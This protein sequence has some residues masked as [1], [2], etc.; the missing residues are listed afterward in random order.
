M[1]CVYSQAYRRFKNNL[2]ELLDSISLWQK[3]LKVIGGKFGTSVLS[4][5]N[6]LRWLLKFNIFSFI[7]TFSFIIIPQLTVMEKNHLQF[8][9]LEFLTGA[10][11]A[12]PTPGVHT[13]KPRTF[14]LA[15]VQAS[16]LPESQL[17]QKWVFKMLS[18][19]FQSDTHNFGRISVSRGDHVNGFR[20]PESSSLHI[21]G[22]DAQ[23]YTSFFFQT[24]DE[25]FI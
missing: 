23:T 13:W 18:I 20:C 15:P 19:F 3:T 10:V 22:H 12:P 7:V 14:L 1:L 9:G 4:Y 6:F 24:K 25:L 11:S 2:S 17:M 16:R 21:F 5:F 8:T